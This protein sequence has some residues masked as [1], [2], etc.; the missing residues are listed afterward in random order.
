MAAGGRLDVSALSDEDLQ[1]YILADCQAPESCIEGAAVDATVA[2][3]AEYIEGW[4]PPQA[5][6]YYLV[7]DM[8]SP[9]LD[10][11]LWEYQLTLAL[12]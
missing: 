10:P 5:G 4:S 1:L 2:G 8:Y 6:R 12:Q 11:L 3:E 9:P 7:V